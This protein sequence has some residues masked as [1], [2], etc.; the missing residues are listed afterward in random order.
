MYVCVN[1]YVW[2][3]VYPFSDKS[4]NHSWKEKHEP[5]NTGC[6]QG[7]PLEASVGRKMFS[8]HLFTL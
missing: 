8:A 2:T 3:Y 4:L 5:G 7:G 6:L 1:V